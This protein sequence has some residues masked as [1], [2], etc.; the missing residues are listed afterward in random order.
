LVL[1]FGFWFLFVGFLFVGVVVVVV[2][3]VVSGGCYVGMAIISLHVL[4]CMWSWKL[5]VKG[6]G[7]KPF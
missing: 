2:V 3:V 4:R 6:A 5:M 7:S 1:V